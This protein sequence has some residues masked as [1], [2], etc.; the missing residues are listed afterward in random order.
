[1][2]KLILTL[3]LYYQ[4]LH[5]IFPGPDPLNAHTR[6]IIVDAQAPSRYYAD[7][8]MQYKLKYH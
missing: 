3:Y 6:Q 5:Y 2:P 8:S 7:T 4:M 1:M